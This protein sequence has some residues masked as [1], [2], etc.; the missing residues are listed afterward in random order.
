MDRW[1]LNLLKKNKIYNSDVKDPRILKKNL[2]NITLKSKFIQKKSISIYHCRNEKKTILAFY[3]VQID[4]E[5]PNFFLFCFVLV[6]SINTSS[7]WHLQLSYQN[8][9]F[10]SV[11]SISADDISLLWYLFHS[12]FLQDWYLNKIRIHQMITQISGGYRSCYI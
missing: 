12:F 9:K 7:V 2:T 4:F 3:N 11:A 10:S 5:H 1:F 6:V 8:V